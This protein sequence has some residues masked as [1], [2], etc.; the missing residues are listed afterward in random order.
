MATEHR[1]LSCLLNL[2]SVAN[3]RVLHSLPSADQREWRD[4]SGKV[5]CVLA[6][7]SVADFANSLRSRGI[8]PVYRSANIDNISE[9]DLAVVT[10]ALDIRTVLDLRTISEVESAAKRGSSLQALKCF[11]TLDWDADAGQWRL[12]PGWRKRV[13]RGQARTSPSYVAQEAAS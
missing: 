13:V 7:L 11:S 1:E 10:E 12:G 5:G 6:G 4:F 2:A 8:A 9:E 3:L